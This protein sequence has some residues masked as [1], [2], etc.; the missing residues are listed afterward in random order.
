MKKVATFASFFVYTRTRT[1]TPLKEYL[2][3]NT[4]LRDI[5]KKYYEVSPFYTARFIKAYRD[6]A[7][8]CN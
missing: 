7:T 1:R 2:V 5:T 4:N 3:L 8:K 6:P